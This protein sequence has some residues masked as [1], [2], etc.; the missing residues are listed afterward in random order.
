M[1]TLVNKYPVTRL[2]TTILLVD[3]AIW[4]WVGA[5]AALHFLA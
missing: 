3:L 5:S 1:K 2:E 4:V